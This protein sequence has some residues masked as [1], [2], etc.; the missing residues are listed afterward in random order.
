MNPNIFDVLTVE[1]GSLKNLSEQL[2]LTYNAVYAWKTRGQKIP[3]KNVA[4][5]E[6]LSNMR[7]TRQMMRPDKFNANA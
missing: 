3:L 1:F 6:E 2:G 5:I 4:R 7:I